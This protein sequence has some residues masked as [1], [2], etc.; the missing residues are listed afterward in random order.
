MKTIYENSVNHLELN[1]QDENPSTCTSNVTC[2][3]PSLV[4]I[5]NDSTALHKFIVTTDALPVGV[6]SKL[7]KF[8]YSVAD[9]GNN[10]NDSY[11][12]FL[13]I[14]KPVTNG[15]GATDLTFNN[16]THEDL[17]YYTIASNNKF[18]KMYYDIFYNDFTLDT[19]SGAIYNHDNSYY[20]GSNNDYIVKTILDD[21]NNI[22][23]HNFMIHIQSDNNDLFSIEYSI[24]NGNS[25]ST[26]T[27]D[28]LDNKI[29]VSSGFT[30]LQIKFKWTGSN[31][32]YS[33]GVFY[34]YISSN[35]IISDISIID[36]PLIGD[37]SKEDIIY[38]SILN[39]VDFKK[40]YFD[41]FKNDTSLDIVSGLVYDRTIT[42]YRG[43]LNSYLTKV[44]L[45]S[46]NTI[47]YTDFMVH[48]E[49]NDNSLFSV[50]YSTNNES[51]WTT[52]TNSDIDNKIHISSGF[53]SL[54][55]KI[56]W[57]DDA[58]LNSFGIFYDSTND[59]WY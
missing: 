50:E 54:S 37:V 5:T 8:T 59:V 43:A 35:N 53:K 42:S 56:S 32:L 31:I 1:V 52:I 9:S 29:Y 57:L 2:D 13:V 55:I 48:L 3:D 49:S 4:S 7:V 15:S 40:C 45:D 58:I 51:S 14:R 16:I 27:N 30:S 23:Y 25:W 33:F 36:N 6:D 39:S 20:S 22:T 21:D 26:I 38:Y 41:V 19:V 17:I 44:I 12:Y 28:R 24:N 34:D 46:S 18:N 47:T 11:E 10:I